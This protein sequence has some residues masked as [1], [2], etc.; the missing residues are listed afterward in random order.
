MKTFPPPNHWIER[1]A[2]PR[3]ILI[4]AAVHPLRS[5]AEAQ[6]DLKVTATVAG[7]S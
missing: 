4:A 5:T 1:P 6:Y 3:E 2:A 7:Y